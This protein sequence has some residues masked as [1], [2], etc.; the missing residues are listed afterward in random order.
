MKLE[1]QPYQQPHV[2]SQR[3]LKYKLDLSIAALS[4]LFIT[5]NFLEVCYY[6]LS[7]FLQ[8]AMFYETRDTGAFLILLLRGLLMVYTF[9]GCV[10]ILLS[11]KANLIELYKKKKIYSYKGIREGGQLKIML[12]EMAIFSV[13]PI[14]LLNFEFSVA[15]R[16]IKSFYNFDQITSVF[17]V[18][19]VY[20]IIKV[21]PEIT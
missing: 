17:A 3:R 11:T 2:M 1:P 10:L 19:K 8:A 7:I 6:S 14:I 13:H 9:T 21:L 12:F 16:G 5:T 15:Q 18:L 4:M 20:F